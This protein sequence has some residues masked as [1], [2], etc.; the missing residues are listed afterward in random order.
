[1]PTSIAAMAFGQVPPRVIVGT[2]DEE[3]EG[4]GGEAT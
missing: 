2:H 3:S 1:M 4:G